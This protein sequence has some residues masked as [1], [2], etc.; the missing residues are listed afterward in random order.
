MNT[1]S[2]RIKAF[3]QLFL[4]DND[5][6]QSALHELLGNFNNQIGWDSSMSLSM[7]MSMSYSGQLPS[8]VSTSPI[9][10][11]APTT[12]SKVSPAPINSQAPWPTDAKEPL[13]PSASMAP[14]ATPPTKPVF[15]SIPTAQLIPVTTNDESTDLH[16]VEL[17]KATR[18][19]LS[20]G[21][22][23]GIAVAAVV[24]VVAAAVAA[25]KKNT[26]LSAVP[27]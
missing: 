3:H 9:H 16:D 22:I 14:S 12:R 1:N 11:L 2:T 5:G 27:V 6:L 4:T 21:A 19:G 25:K 23:A 15:V 24:A 18:G 26:P 7:S 20:K 10:A 8:P 17:S 13:P